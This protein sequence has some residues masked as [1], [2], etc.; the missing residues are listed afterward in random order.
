MNEDIKG[1]LELLKE[2]QEHVGKQVATLF[3][4]PDTSILEGTKLKE[5]GS[6]KAK[7]TY[8]LSW[9]IGEVTEQEIID[10]ITKVHDN[11]NKYIKEINDII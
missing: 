4:I 3:V 11:I 7:N 6:V 9:A 5:L 1:V 8:H 10:D 2:K